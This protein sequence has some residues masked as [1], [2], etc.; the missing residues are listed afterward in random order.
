MLRAVD[1]QGLA[2]AY[3]YGTY[4][5]GFD[6]IG[7]HEL[8]GGFGIKNVANNLDLFGSEFPISEG[9][10]EAW[11]V[12]RDVD[13][14]FGNP[15]CSGFSLLNTSSG[16]S[17]RGSKSK[18]N[19]CMWA[20]AEYG[21]RLIARDGGPPPVMA[22]ESVQGAFK[23]GRD[24]MQDLRDFVEDRTGYKYTLTHVLMSGSTVGAAATRR[25]YFWVIHR[26][27]FGVEVDERPR[28]ATYRDAIFDL[29]GLDA[30]TWENQTP[31]HAPSDW[32]F[33]WDMLQRDGNVD[34]HIAMHDGLTKGRAWR[35]WNAVLPYWKQGEIFETAVR[36]ANN[37]IGYVPGPWEEQP[38]IDTHR[39]GFQQPKRIKWDQAAYVLTGGGMWQFVHPDEDRWLTVREMSRIQGFPDT[40]KYPDENIRWASLW[41]GK[42]VPVQSGYW[43]SR[44][45]SNSLQGS[46]GSIRGELI[47]D[48][49]FK[50]DVTNAYKEFGNDE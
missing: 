44:W 35:R 2:G 16:D 43:L 32:L 34:A 5:A 27:P 4:K 50:I 48:N 45:V 20:F 7:K 46:P 28:V 30:F 38:D 40:W 22:F 8:P 3:T 39:F 10:M 26:L 33:E 42:G 21:T 47:G 9:P 17:A 14:V 29:K 1:C 11:P 24:L 49:E 18:I 37:E 6:I 23:K 12:Y 41:I 19:D 15:P 13:Y 36:R 25:R 31:R